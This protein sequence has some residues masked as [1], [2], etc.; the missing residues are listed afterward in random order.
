LPLLKTCIRHANRLPKNQL[1]LVSGP[2]VVSRSAIASVLDAALDDQKATVRLILLA[3]VN[4]PR[5]LHST[6]CVGPNVNRARGYALIKPP[7]DRVPHKKIVTLG[8]TGAGTDDKMASEVRLLI[9]IV[10]WIATKTPEIRSLVLV[11]IAKIRRLHH[12]TIDIGNR[13]V[14]ESRRHDRL[15]VPAGKG[16]ARDKEKRYKTVPSP[17]GW[18]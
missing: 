9:G 12:A 7:A 2:P 11:T 16:T 15:T 8:S 10:R 4:N 1:E 13:K 6:P 14:F 3:L 18:C 5:R 17:A